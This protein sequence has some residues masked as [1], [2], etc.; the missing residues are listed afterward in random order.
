LTK[1]SVHIKDTDA[2]IKVSEILYDVK[3][4]VAK[5]SLENEIPGE[6]T[7]ILTIEFKGVI[8]QEVSEWCMYEPIVHF[9]ELTFSLFRWPDSTAVHTRHPK[10]RVTGCI[11]LN[12]NPVMHAEHSLGKF[13]CP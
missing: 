1:G 5:L 6:G 3:S 7:G 10:T 11:R 2:T 4:Q 8:N 9:R 12:S 13:A